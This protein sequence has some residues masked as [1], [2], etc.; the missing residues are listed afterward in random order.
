MRKAA[1][2]KQKN[3]RIRRPVNVRSGTPR[4]TPRVPDHF[5]AVQESAFLS[6]IYVKMWERTSAMQ[7]DPYVIMRALT[8]KRIRFVLTGTHG[9]SGW[10][11]EPRATKD[12]DILVKGGRTLTRAIKVIKA[13]F[14]HLVVREFFGVHGFFEPDATQ[15][16]VDVMHPHREDLQETLAHPIWVERAGFRFRIPS[17]EAALANKYGAMLTPNRL[18]VKREQDLVD[19]QRM[20]LHSQKPGNQTV[21]EGRLASLGEKVWPGGGG[22]EILHLVQRTRAG[23]SLGLNDLSKPTE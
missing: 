1:D 23:R 15:S 3:D 2:A 11:G 14:P 4:T 17:L 13:L 12:V 8:A 7:V 9:I 18:V 6:K 20:V 10:T 16:I 5:H 22:K 21:D 19:F